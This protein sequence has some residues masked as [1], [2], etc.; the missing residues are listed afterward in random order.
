MTV[1]GKRT[2]ALMGI[3]VAMV[4]LASAVLGA[5]PQQQSTPQAAP[6]V[7]GKQHNVP[8][9]GHSK[10]KSKT[11][12]DDWEN[13]QGGSAPKHKTP[14]DHWVGV[15]TGKSKGSHSDDW[16][17]TDASVAKPGSK[18]NPNTAS[19]HSNLRRAH[20]PFKTIQPKNPK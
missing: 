15:G 2:C 3:G 14:H 13:S 20:K 8:K 11:F 7:K 18:S 10:S 19:T 16:I 12:T 4:I 17:T 9:N 5:A 1:I 6:L